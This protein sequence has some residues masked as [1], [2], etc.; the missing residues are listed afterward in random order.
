MNTFNMDNLGAIFLNWYSPHMYTLSE[1]VLGEHI[2][3][4]VDYKF[5]A[6]QHPFE[7]FLVHMSKLYA[8]GQSPIFGDA[9]SYICVQELPTD[10]RNWLISLLLPLAV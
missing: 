6:P 7:P 8:Y 5:L 4:Y 1:C 3:V 10:K 2:V 9:V